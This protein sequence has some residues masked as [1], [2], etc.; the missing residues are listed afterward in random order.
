MSTTFNSKSL[1]IVMQ[2]EQKRYSDLEEENT[3]RHFLNTKE[4]ILL[5]FLEELHRKGVGRKNEIEEIV[6]GHEHGSEKRKCHMQLFIKFA[7]SLINKGTTTLKFTN[8]GIFQRIQGIR[9]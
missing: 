4:A 8:Y 7:G 1:G 6:I 2:M 5:G 3:E 9:H